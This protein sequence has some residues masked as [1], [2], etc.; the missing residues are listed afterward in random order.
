[1]V[2]VDIKKSTNSEKKLMAIFYDEKLKKIKTVHFGASGY[3]DYIKSGGDD[4]RKKRYIARHSNG[5]EDWNNYM[6]PGSLSRWI[7]WNLPTLQASI[8]DYKKKFNLL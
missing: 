7:L 2:K 6:T 5:T 4:E 1:M 3:T 8:K